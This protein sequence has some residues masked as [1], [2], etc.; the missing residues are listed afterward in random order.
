MNTGRRR[1]D[2]KQE[3]EREGENRERERERGRKETT[4]QKSEYC[5]VV[6]ERERRTN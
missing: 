5:R 3:D 2:E 1:D 4:H 6:M